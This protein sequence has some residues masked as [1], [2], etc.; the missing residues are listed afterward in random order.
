M[1]EDCK[2]SADG[3]S[4]SKESETTRASTLKY[5]E[6]KSIHSSDSKNQANWTLWK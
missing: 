5:F 3:R 6:T 2:Q 1:N 4:V